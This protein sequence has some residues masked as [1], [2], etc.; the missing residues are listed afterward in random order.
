MP[1]SEYALTTSPDEGRRLRRLSGTLDSATLAFLDSVGRPESGR[2]LDVG[3]GSGG[4]AVE[5]A[6]RSPSGV[7]TGVDLEPRRIAEARDHAR[8]EAVDNVEF[9]VAPADRLPFPDRHFDLVSCR[10]LLMHLRAPG[11]AV[12]EMLRVLRPGGLFAAVETDWGGQL[13]HPETP[14]LAQARELSVRVARH[15]GIEPYLG[16]RLYGLLTGRGLAGVTVEAAC[17]VATAADPA[18]AVEKLESRI[19]MLTHLEDRLVGAG[20]V[21][22]P[23]VAAAVAAVRDLLAAADLC[24]TDLRFFAAGRRP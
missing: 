22:E 17:T 9:V 10:F 1:R 2:F 14:E 15:L 19:R 4:L 6:R 5:L 7:A 23:E 18:G 11:A 3:C 13:V 8:T 12:E 16:R 21:T 20:L 24:T